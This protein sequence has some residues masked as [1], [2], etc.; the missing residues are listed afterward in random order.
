MSD[1]SGLSESFLGSSPPSGGGW[2]GHGGVMIKEE[3]D[4]DD[5]GGHGMHGGHPRSRGE[6]E[7]G[8]FWP[9]RPTK[10]DPSLMAA[11]VKA[12]TVLTNLQRGN[13][14]TMQTIIVEPTVASVHQRAGQVLF[15][16]L[17]LLTRKPLQRSLSIK[18]TG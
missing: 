7:K 12:N 4:G 17:L 11:G 5:H 3:M 14:P 15:Q 8:T 2:Q 9:Q 13:I 10:A 1:K 6:K 16:C 18:C